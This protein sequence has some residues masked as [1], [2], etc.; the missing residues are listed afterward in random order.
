MLVLVVHL[1]M[2]VLPAVGVVR[3]N[4]AELTKQFGQAGQ[5]RASWKDGGG[6]SGLG[7]G[8]GIAQQ[9]G[10]MGQTQPLS[11]EQQQVAEAQ[12]KKMQQAQM[13]SFGMR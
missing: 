6:L 10:L 3:Q 9:G 11:P 5:V 2:E 12:R 7:Q 8:G 1:V 4:Q 13:Q